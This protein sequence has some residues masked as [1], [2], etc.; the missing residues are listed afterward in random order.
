[1]ADNGQIEDTQRIR[2]KISL[3]RDEL[4]TK[5]EHLNHTYDNCVNEIGRER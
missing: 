2:D 5:L 1:M 3:E 4:H